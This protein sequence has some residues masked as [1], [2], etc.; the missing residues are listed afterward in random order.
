MDEKMVNEK[1]K[2]TLR[3]ENP[4]FIVAERANVEAVTENPA[5]TKGAFGKTVLLLIALFIATGVSTFLTIEPSTWLK[6]A[7]GAFGV[8]IVICRNPQ[9]T[10]T[11]APLYVVMEGILLGQI[12][13]A[14]EKVYP[15]IA[16]QTLVVTFVIAAVVAAGYYFRWVEV[17]EVFKSRVF[18]VTAGIAAVY[19]VDLVLLLGFGMQVPMI[20]ESNWKGVLA[21]LFVIS[22][23]AMNLAWDFDEICTL[24]AKGLPKYYEWY[25]G[26]GV[27]VT[28]I[29]LYVEAM[30]LLRKITRFL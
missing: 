2:E 7:L 30:Q 24:S 28:L 11:L 20:H 23:A 22:V 27:V 14:E 8:G 6:L 1:K 9:Y 26:F 19:L 13:L 12:A 15:G 5:T 29:W 21:S 25:F 16:V 4:V 10:A 17:N 3:N 18:L